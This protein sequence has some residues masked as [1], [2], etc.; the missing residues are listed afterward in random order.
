MK[1]WCFLQ[2]LPKRT[3][4]KSH[5][6]VSSRGAYN[7]STDLEDERS[8]NVSV[9]WLIYRSRPTTTPWPATILDIARVSE[10][11]NDE[12]GVTGL[13]LFSNDTYLQYAEGPKDAIE[14]LWARLYTDSR[15]EILW[16]VRG[17]DSTR[18]VPGLP[19]GYF[20][21]DREPGTAVETA[22]W[23]NRQEWRPEQADELKEMLIGLARQKYPSLFSNGKP[24]PS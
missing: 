6:I 9:H 12:P 23:R 4:L 14:A 8:V 17:V 11:G 10:A 3:C 20:D 18:R 16:H 24:E 19:M 1:D 21:A 22:L 7:P 2:N 13:L 5:L 15:H